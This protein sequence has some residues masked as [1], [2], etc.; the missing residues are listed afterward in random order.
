MSLKE[1]H[2]KQNATKIAIDMKI[3]D[4]SISVEKVIE[5]LNKNKV[6]PEYN[7]T[8]SNRINSKDNSD[9]MQKI[10]TKEINTHTIESTLPSN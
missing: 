3:A 7:E 2:K 8:S 4:K 5:V 10:N 6:L 1:S 9:S